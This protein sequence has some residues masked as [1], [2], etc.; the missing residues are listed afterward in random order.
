MHFIKKL[1]SVTFFLSIYISI[2]GQMTYIGLKDESNVRNAQNLL[3]NNQVETYW[4]ETQI[5]DDYFYVPTV[6]GIYRKNLNTLNTTDWELYAFDGIPIIDFIKNNDTIM[7]ATAVWS[8]KELLLLSVD[9]GLTYI[10]YTPSSFPYIEDKGRILRITQNPH[11]RNTIAFMYIG[12]GGVSLSRDFGL[13]WEHQNTIIGGYQDW[14][15]GFNPNDT[16]NIFH[17]GEQMFFSSYI[18]ATYNNGA[19]WTTVEEIH[20]HCTHNIAFHPFDKNIMVSGGEGRLA[21]STNQGMSWTTVESV[22]EYVFKIIYD[23]QNPN[24]LYAV[25][26]EHGISYNLRILRSIDGG[27]N[28]HV[29]YEEVIE[30]SD[31]ILDIHLHNNK[32][33]VYTLVNGVYYL[34]LNTVN[35]EQIESDNQLIIYP[36]PF[37]LYLNINSD[38]TMQNIKIYD[39][40]G[41]HIFEEILNTTNATIHLN[42][43]PLGLYLLLI[44]TEKGLVTRKVLKK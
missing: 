19:S 39:S 26:D 37:E 1:I 34:D 35:I 41:K 21:K 32:L 24:I 38:Y 30:D 16:T 18:K 2:Y 33:I 25:G 20:N 40:Q 17:T 4:T 43:L 14:F 3:L 15:L 5:I 12:R 8:D 23:N 22:Y 31:G 44:D 10:D 28:W 29:F 11:N 27:D 7:A 42:K 36:N 9:D 6:K 13:S